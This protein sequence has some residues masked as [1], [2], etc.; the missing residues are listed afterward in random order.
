MKIKN[1]IAA[2]IPFCASVFMLVFSKEVRQG[3]LDG[4]IIAQNTI[5][6]S[7]L[8]LL[9]I[10]L[11]IMKSGA[12]DVLSRLFGRVITAVFNLPMVCTPAVIFGIIGGYP[13]GALLTY[14]L[15]KNDNIDEV[16]AREM[17][18]FNFCGGCG[19]IITAVGSAR[20]SSTRLGVILLFS[21]IL[22]CITIGFVRSFFRK[23][24]SFEFYSYS[25]DCNVGDALTSAVEDA[26]KSVINIT[27]YIVLFSAFFS[28]FSVSKYI[29]PIFEIT[30]GVCGEESYTLPLISSYLA[31]GGIC[32][33][34]Q[35]LPIINKLNMKYYDFFAY[36]LIGAGLSY[37]YAKLLFHFFPLEESVFSSAGECIAQVSSVNPA[38][39]FLLAAG[40]FILILDLRAKR[41][42]LC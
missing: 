17:L 20:L 15:Y 34:L 42:I 6:P 7:L 11:F 14:E 40:C 4:L 37:L 36:R 19:F 24:C 27:A 10:F 33:H 3:A 35:L 23:R 18:R 41:N 30:S 31:F 21:N 9:I 1:Y 22:S 5:V 38:L 13:T 25:K 12:G 26:V 16:Q 2:A 28:M 39:S 8:P 29:I 32:I